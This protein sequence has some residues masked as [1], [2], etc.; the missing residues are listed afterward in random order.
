[1][2]LGDGIDGWRVCWL[3]GWDRGKVFFVVMVDAQSAAPYPVSAAFLLLSASGLRAGDFAAAIATLGAADYDSYLDIA[4]KDDGTIR[5]FTKTVRFIGVG[6]R[7]YEVPT[8]L[9]LSRLP[10][11]LAEWVKIID[12]YRETPNPCGLDRRRRFHYLSC[13]VSEVRAQK[14]ATEARISSAVFVHAKGLG[15]GFVISM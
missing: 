14:R 2:A 6:G 4:A 1:V 5:E 13:P 3:A 12:F 11:H 15:D 9:Y 7:G 10:D 8:S